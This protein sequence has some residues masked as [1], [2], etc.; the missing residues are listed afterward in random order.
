M[1]TLKAEKREY[2]KPTNEGLR[3]N[4]RIPAVFY[5]AKNETT[6][7]SV[8]GKEFLPIWKEAKESSVITIDTPIGKLK[9]L[10]NEVQLN[11]VTDE[12]IHID[13]YVVE[14]DKKTEAS[15]SLDFVGVSP[16]IKEL[17]CILVK[18][19]REIEVEAL[20]QD[21]PKNIKVDLSNLVNAESRILIE[22]ISLPKGVKATA[23][24]NEVVALAEEAK[25]EEESTE[26]EDV[27]MSA[28]EVEKKGKK[29]V[30]PESSDT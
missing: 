25:E 14:K 3:E 29:E 18:V 16:A 26:S 13:F 21:L 11:P 27:D 2:K 23:S 22:N 12:P 1:L 28:I 9:V 6:S 4:G 24:A 19:M 20:P 30:E 5:G 7:V 10:I 17:G 15:I 8:D